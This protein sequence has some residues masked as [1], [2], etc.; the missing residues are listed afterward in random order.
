MHDSGVEGV[1]ASRAKGGGLKRSPWSS[2]RPSEFQRDRGLLIPTE[3]E[4]TVMQSQFV[5][6]F[7]QSTIVTVVL[8]LVLTGAVNV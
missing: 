3:K 7:L 8:G 5:L 1:G 6:A 2:R 4:T